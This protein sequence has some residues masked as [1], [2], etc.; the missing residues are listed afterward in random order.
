M[1]TVERDLGEIK[2]KLDMILEGQKT[3]AGRQESMDTRLRQVENRSA[4]M[5]A[6]GAILVTVGLELGRFIL[7]KA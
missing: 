3:L 5:G 6:A 7:K 2:G 1:S 4:I